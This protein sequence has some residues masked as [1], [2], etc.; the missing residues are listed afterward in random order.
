MGYAGSKNSLVLE[1]TADGW[2]LRTDAGTVW[3]LRLGLLLFGPGLTALLVWLWPRAE[4][5]EAPWPIV[6]CVALFAL[7]GWWFLGRS[8]LYAHR[9]E[10]SR[11][12]RSLRLYRTRRGAP[13]ATLRSSDV[14]RLGRDVVRYRPDD[15][16]AVVN[17]VL[18]LIGL[19]DELVALCASPNVQR[20]DQL[21]RELAEAL[22]AK[23]SR[24]VPSP[25]L[26][27]PN[28]ETPKPET[29]LRPTLS[30]ER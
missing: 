22:G 19:R 17:Q 25:E 13:V 5:G 18:Q 8:W 9:A 14:V 6:A 30:A 7:L 2:V 28:P 10:L 27:T 3:I 4:R 23:P 11:S 24:N 12:T 21:E 15:G 1:P 29:A 26:A 20:I 16:P